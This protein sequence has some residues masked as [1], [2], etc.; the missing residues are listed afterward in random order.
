MAEIFSPEEV[1][2]VAAMVTTLE[3]MASGEGDA[4]TAGADG[5]SKFDKLTAL[6]MGDTQPVADQVAN[7]QIPKA[8]IITVLP[9]FTDKDIQTNYTLLQNANSMV[10]LYTN[11]MIV[12][13]KPDGY[14]ITTEAAKA[15]N[16]Q[17]S[18]A[19][20]AMM[21]QMPGFW[22][23]G[24][25]SVKKYSNN[26]NQ[27][28]IHEKFLGE[29]FDGYGFDAPTK[30]QLDAILTN[31][32]AGV[33]TLKPGN[34]RP[35]TQDF[36]LRLNLC[37]AINITGD[38]N[39]VINVYQPTTWVIYLKFNADAY[40]QATGKNSSVDKIKFAYDYT[41]AKCELNT[42]LFQAN[43]PRFDQ[44]FQLVA[45]KSL[46]QFSQDLMKQYEVKTDVKNAGAGA[47]P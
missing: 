11:M 46:D 23:F 8:P 21:R 41:V 2:Q 14:D 38:P 4:V 30:K 28:E 45:G 33:K 24:M 3:K 25:G 12:K 10:Q 19:Y 13:D 32:V 29:L 5:D 34:D 20:N 1:E 26:L 39:N 37:P 18:Y 22:N 9:N 7:G 40:S 31:F 16:A 15:F 47:K 44:I 43:K 6:L 35:S 17:A 36:C 42:Q 27:S